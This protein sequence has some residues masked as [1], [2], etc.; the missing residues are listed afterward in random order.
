MIKERIQK[1][2]ELM[3]D[4]NIGLYIVPTSDYHGSE[5]ISDFFKVRQY[6][7]GFTGSAGTLLISEKNAYLFADGR[8]FIQA[9]KEISGTGIQLMKMGLDG[10]PTLFELLEKELESGKNI[11]VD[12]FL[13]STSYG[14]TLEKIAKH[15][16]AKVIGIDLVGKIW[17]DRA[18]LPKDRVFILDKKYAGESYKSKL[19]RIK[20]VMRDNHCTSHI[21]SSLTDIAWIL[22]MR[23]N[24][25]KCTPV[26]LSYLIIKNNGVQLFI[27][28]N[29]LDE[30]VKAYLKENDIAVYDYN[31]IGE[32]VKKLGGHVLIDPDNLNYGIYNLLKAKK[33][34]SMY[35]STKMKAIK[36]KVE[37]KNIKEAHV[38]DAVAMC[39]FMYWLKTN[40]GKIPMSEVSIQDYLYELRSKQ[41]NYLGPS[42]TT[43]CAYQDHGAM[44][45][46]NATKES[47]VK[48]N[49][50]G[51]L[52]VDSG[53]H[54][55]EGTTDITR[56]FA[57]GALSEEEKCHFTTVLQSV[58][59]LARA[60]FLKGCRGINLD[61]LAREPI[62]NLYLD[63][64]CGTGHGVSYLTSVHEGPQG[65]RWQIGERI[66]NMTIL[67]PGMVTTDE[68]G[69]YLEGKYGIRTENE[70]LCVEDKTNIDGTFLA[71]ECVTYVPIDLDAIDK[72]YLTKES[73]SYLNDYHK[74]VY[75]KIS[76][77]LNKEEKEFLKE[78]TRAI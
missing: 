7:S 20:K 25:V 48:V 65:F 77:Y 52:L 72:K 14:K 1:I 30:N 73:V 22:N 18:E 70:L 46:Y 34:E 61:V 15:K 42:F 58:I 39:K 36:N 26:F 44:M 62:W 40:V 37:I 51:L 63:Y 57:L 12:T 24:D 68:P 45:H 50:Q 43:I 5:Y 33:V 16:G 76:P 55:L 29:K 56:T 31:K 75:K 28:K 10:V 32:E 21:V 64:K 2:R 66:E 8:Y 53:G 47:D 17:K 13:I 74:M 71:F 54:Y 9:E 4:A 59:N 3:K 69:I 60:R 78:Y 49:K 23:G 41:D 38:K 19:K 67:E 27:D 6:M 11:G 35:P